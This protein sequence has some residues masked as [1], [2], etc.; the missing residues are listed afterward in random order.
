MRIGRLA[1]SK[2]CFNIQPDFG[3]RSF[4]DFGDCTCESF[5]YWLKANESVKSYRSD[6][7]GERQ[8]H[9]ANRII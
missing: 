3:N 4:Y 9:Y 5:A 7:Y 8:Y 2:F 6:D 1:A